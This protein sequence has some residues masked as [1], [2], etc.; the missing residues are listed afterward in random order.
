MSSLTLRV[1]S[2]YLS[3]DVAAPARLITGKR[4]GLL[5][6]RYCDQYGNWYNRKGVVVEKVKDPLDLTW[7]FPIQIGRVYY[8]PDRSL[9][10]ILEYWAS[11]ENVGI[12]ILVDDKDVHYHG[13]DSGLTPASEEDEYLFNEMHPEYDDGVWEDEPPVSFTKPLMMAAAVGAS[14]AL[15]PHLALFR[16]TPQK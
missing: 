10:K 11:F 5:G 1:G 6:T 2:F 14:V 9:C 4:R 7:E 3:T 12:H 13:L 16:Q 15:V 8:R